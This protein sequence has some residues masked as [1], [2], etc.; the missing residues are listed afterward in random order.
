[1]PHSSP[2]PLSVYQER[3]NAFAADLAAAQR[4]ANSLSNARLAVALAA[5][6][7]FIWF[8]FRDDLIPCLAIV[9]A[10][11]G[12]FIFLMARHDKVLARERRSAQMVAL[13]ESG[14][15]RMEGRWNRC[16]DDGREYSDADHPFAADLDLF[17]PSSLFQWLNAAQTRFGR[18]LFR[19]L[20]ASPPRSRD[21]IAADQEMVRELAPRLDWRQRYQAAGGAPPA[22]KPGEDP[23]ALLAWAEDTSELFRS[24]GLASALRFLPLLS[25]AY[26][27]AMFFQHGLSYLMLPPFLLHAL[28]ASANQKRNGKVLSA[29]SRQKR[30]L[31]VYLDLLTQAEGGGFAG[32][33]LRELSSGLR[34]AGGASASSAV[35]ALQ[36]LADHLETRL[37]PMLHFLV[38]TLFLWD[39]QWLW[40]FRAWR[41]DNGSGLRSWL[42]ILAR[43]EVAS[44]LAIPAF[45]N[46]DWAFPDIGA[47]GETGPLLA[48]S[49][50]AHPLIPKSIR[51]GNDVRLASPGE[52]LIITGSN[53]SGKSTL[54][55]A[56]G[57]NLVLAYAGAPVCAGAFRCGR[58]EMHTSMRLKDDLEKRISSFYAELL[59]IKGIVDAAQSGRQVLFLIDEIFRGTNS[60]DRHAGAMAVLR[61]LHGLK[62][63]GLVST[64]DL[65]LASLEETDP[66][67]FRNFHFQ[68]QYG[69]GGI[70]FDY[71]MRAG[72]S[73]TTNA[74]HLLRMVGLADA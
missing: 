6:A 48:A 42:G 27:G 64:H 69:E 1:M 7:G 43:L 33:G 40:V 29:I 20:L 37:N 4:S 39:L 65:E 58:M 32:P 41:R 56:V 16:E 30:N 35:R 13:N 52:V 46:P 57:A 50:L 74:M 12:L 73:T 21:A 5:F 61:R 53:M 72:V 54:M 24:P 68:E 70:A 47:E 26:A 66:A 28:I 36:R 17:G 14:I 15:A 34:N 60:K 67:S 9:A 22:R 44:S 62:A 19:Q 18:E 55:R 38:N 10:G 11:V 45:E 63:A 2:D 31:E 23:E 3:R 49:S 59:R 8:V 25:F 51:V 71:R